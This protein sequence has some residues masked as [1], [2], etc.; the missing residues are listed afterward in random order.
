MISPWRP[1]ALGPRGRL[2]LLAGAATGRA[3]GVQGAPVPPTSEL[4]PRNFPATHDWVREQLAT[5]PNDSVEVPLTEPE[6]S[7]PS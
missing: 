2:F 7:L 4:L 6:F 3:T 5:L 1:D